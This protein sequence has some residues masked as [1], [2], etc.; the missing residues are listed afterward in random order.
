M[1]KTLC[2][3]KKPKGYHQTV[4]KYTDNSGMGRLGRHIYTIQYD[5]KANFSITTIKLARIQT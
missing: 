2:N 1:I 3:P 4:Q 5:D